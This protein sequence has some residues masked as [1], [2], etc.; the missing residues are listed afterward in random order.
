MHSSLFLDE[1]PRPGRIF[2]GIGF[3]CQILLL[4]LTQSFGLHPSE[5]ARPTTGALPFE[6]RAWMDTQDQTNPNSNLD[7]LPEVEPESIAE[8]EAMLRYAAL[9]GDTSLTSKQK[10][11]AA[12]SLYELLVCLW[13]PKT[14]G[15]PWISEI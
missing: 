8:A 10:L 15:K 3:V 4:S 9:I 7:Y 13:G 5:D 6:N 14:S 11:E 2:F 12:C 1:N